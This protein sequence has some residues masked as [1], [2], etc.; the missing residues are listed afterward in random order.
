MTREQ[1]LHRENKLFFV[2]FF[3]NFKQTIPIRHQFL[4]SFALNLTVGFNKVTDDKNEIE[5]QTQMK[6]LTQNFKA[7]EQLVSVT[8]HTTTYT[9]RYTY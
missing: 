3:G 1:L 9:H 2:H 6:M 4:F 7:N 8:H 5:K